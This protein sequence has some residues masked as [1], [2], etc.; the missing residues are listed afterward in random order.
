MHVLIAGAASRIGR[1]VATR[2]VAEPGID[3]V[4]GLDTRAC[5]PPVPGQRF[6]RAALE[7][8][9]WRPTLAEA[10]AMIVLPGLAWPPHWRAR[11]NEARIANA[12][13]IVLGAAQAADVPHIIVANSAALY[14][15]Q[16]SPD[17]DAQP[18][19]PLPE[20]APVRGHDTSA[21]AR[22]RA[23]IADYLDLFG[24][25]YDGT[26]TRLRA[27]W[28]CGPHHV[29][30]LRQFTGE[31]VLACGYEQRALSVIHELD[32]VD[33]LVFALRHR[34]PGTYN[35][36]AAQPLSFNDIAALVGKQVACTPLPWLVLR[37]YVRWRWLRWR[38]PPLWVRGLYH[39]APLDVSVLASAGWQAT[40]P[41]R[42]AF[43][44]T[45][46]VLRAQ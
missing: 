31:P 1:L 14:G 44:E 39:G 32:L 4:T 46:D 18:P 9:E 27:A 35:V 15:A 6:I 22:I 19:A 11:Q 2:L 13:K 40:H 41:A 42:A 43:V 34:L 23:R 5:Y 3:A 37:A 45:L 16:H 33:A 30:L 20:S 8:P 25:S 29:A 7:Q 17:H 36:A 28:L 26:L 24:A 10:D 38:T 21:Y 12:I